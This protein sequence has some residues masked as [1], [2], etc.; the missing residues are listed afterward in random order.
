MRYPHI[1]QHDERDCGAACLCMISEFYGLKLSIARCRELIKVDAFGANVYGLVTG[2]EELGLAS[3]AFY[4][5]AGDLFEGINAGEITFPFIARIINEKQWEHFVVVYSMI[6]DIVYVG[7]PSK[8]QITRINIVD[9]IDQWQGQIITFVPKEDFQKANKRKGE[10]SKYFKLI[11]SQKR[12]LAFVFL[13]SLIIAGI[14]LFSATIFKYIIDDAIVMEDKHYGNNVEDEHEHEH[15]YDTDHIDEDPVIIATI[16]ATIEKTEKV[17]SRVFQNIET[18]CLTII[19]LFLIRSVLQMLRGYLLAVLAKNVDFSLSTGLYNHLIDLPV[20]FFRRFKTGELMARFGDAANIRRAISEV[21]LTIMLDTFMAILVG[22]YLFVMN[23]TLFYITLIVLAFYAL[24]MACLRKPIK[25]RNQNIMEGNARIT[26]FLKESIDG[27]EAVKSYYRE[28]SAKSRA[29]SL[30]ET[31]LGQVVKGSIVVTLQEVLVGAVESI[32]VIVLLW[33]G[34]YLCIEEVLTVGDLIS[35]YY[36]MGYFLTPVKSLIELQ[37]TMQTAAVTAERLS[38]I[39]DVN[40]EVKECGRNVK[41]LKGDIFFDNV[42]F[43]YGNRQL[44]LNGMSMKIKGCSKVA[45]VGESGS[46]KTTIVKLLMRFYSPEKGN[47]S[48]KG[49]DISTWS[50]KSLRR[51]ISYIPQNAFLFSESIYENL[52]MGD[53]QIT[54]DEIEDICKR[55]DADAFIKELPFSY[56]T[57][58]EENGNNLSGGQKQRLAIARAL[59][60][61]PDILI[62]DEAT[63]NMDVISEM[64]I[65]RLISEECKDMTVIVI[66]HRLKTVCNCDTIFVIHDGRVKEEG[67][68]IDLLKQDGIYANYWK[69]QS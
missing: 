27:I 9:F 62:M 32:G 40:T 41:D 4:G 25:V 65:Q 15:N 52:R 66:A 35:F 12:L 13:F 6:N 64:S 44:V 33:I 28:E 3:E 37:P 49:T 61:K 20:S 22:V 50:L 63:S 42:N 26:A 29:K 43:R 16:K 18:V 45:L 7:D 59:L 57:V 31:F 23:H 11:I 30:Y 56:D 38:D 54:N 36:L 51:H 1:R 53:T 14:S 46:G 17:L 39:L 67:K 58:L 10:V 55:C 21:T 34:A 68:H 19:A 60:H 48:I 69:E 47:L 2:A 5:N 8:T 24:I